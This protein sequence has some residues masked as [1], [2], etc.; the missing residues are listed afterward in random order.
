MSNVVK[1]DL[2]LGNKTKVQLGEDENTFVELNLSDAGIVTRLSKAQ[3]DI[4]EQLKAN[5]D[6]WKTLENASGEEV[7]DLLNE[8]EEKIRNLVDYIFDAPVSAAFLKNSS[9]LSIY[10]GE[11]A[12][13]ILISKIFELY[14]KTIANDA[15]AMQ[16]RIKGRNTVQKYIK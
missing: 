8:T 14:E 1:L 7:T 2:N 11:Y 16:K 15:K 5:D 9:A 3:N 10:N 6:K 13:E 4:A 12:Y